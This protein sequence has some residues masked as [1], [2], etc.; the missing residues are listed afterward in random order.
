MSRDTISAFNR[1]DDL[2][3][4][5]A[6]LSASKYHWLRYTDERM[7]EYVENLGAARRGSMQHDLARLAIILGQKLPNTTQ[8]L[9]MY[10]NDAIGYRMTP[11]QPLYYS[12]L[13]FGTSDAICFRE[14]VLRIFDL[15][16]G[17]NKAS[18]DQLLVYAAY[19]CL[20][21]GIKPSDIEFDLR[22]YQNDEVY[23]IDVDPKDI[24]YIMDRIVQLNNLI[25]TRM[26]EGV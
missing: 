1:H 23:V 21:Y 2:K 24:V 25:T 26:E 6:V 13:A 20:E 12:S 22:I 10:V 5:H 3:D 4:K 9:N 11:E 8:T 19:F 17:K 7:Y 14:R 16:N 15:K 18:E